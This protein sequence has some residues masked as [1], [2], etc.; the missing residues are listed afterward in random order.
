MLRKDRP[1]CC[2]L[3]RQGLYERHYEEEEAHRLV[4]ERAFKFS[5]S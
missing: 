3:D 5:S 1:F 2:G 4:K